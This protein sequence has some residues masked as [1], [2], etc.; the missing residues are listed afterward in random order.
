VADPKTTDSIPR[1]AIN[2]ILQVAA[3]L[4]ES[5]GQ[6][7]FNEVRLFLLKRSQRTAPTSQSAMYTVARDVL[8]DLQKLEFLKAGMLPRTQSQLATL[9]EAPCELTDAGRELASLYGEKGTRGRAFDRLMLAW[10]KHHPYFKAFIARLH[11]RTLW[12]PDVTSVKQLGADARVDD[13][14]NT[15]TRRLSDHC[16]QRLDG[17]GLRAPQA[18]SLAKSIHD[19]V[20]ELGRVT[21]SALDAK[22]WVDA[23][24]DRIVIP[25]TLES[26]ALPFSDAVTL[27]HILKAAKDFL[28]AS[29]TSSLPEHS[30]RAVFPTCE[31]R[32][33][34]G[35][36]NDVIDIVHHGK[37]FAAPHFANAVRKAYG[38]AAPGPNA[39][40][41]A[42][43]VRALVCTELQ[44]QPKVFALCLDEL[45][46]IG[47]PSGLTI[48][49]ELPFDPPPPGEDYIEVGRSRI[50]LLKL[51][52]SS[53]GG[54]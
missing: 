20:Q 34:L 42:Y 23:I 12:L 13:N 26:E 30:L 18:E 28:A 40:A 6:S 47:P 54:H 5:K 2:Q 37:S 41:N 33:A 19:R 48:Y 9:G 7:T 52:A 39:Y 36:A 21:L 45:I 10:L 8:L 29:W 27:Q 35:E 32:P 15:L 46:E 51:T 3:L 11:D 38:R 4:A 44:I 1:A 43:A 25:A 14:L 16:L 22:K 50:G 49:T 17:A 53:N 24:Q 31:F